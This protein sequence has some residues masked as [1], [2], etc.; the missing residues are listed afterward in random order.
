MKKKREKKPKQKNKMNGL[1][2]TAFILLMICIPLFV[3]AIIYA[4]AVEDIVL[5]EI[6]S[7]SAV[8]LAMLG[9]IF[10]TCS[11]PKKIKPK[12]KRRRKIEMTEDEE[13]IASE[14]IDLQAVEEVSADEEESTPDLTSKNI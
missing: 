7:I 3:L 1:Y 4:Y 8:F 9:I 13:K 5:M 10:A 6:F 11:K 12:K 2:K 14:S